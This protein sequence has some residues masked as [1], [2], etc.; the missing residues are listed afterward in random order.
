MSDDN[1]TA[2]Q[3]PAIDPVA[4][5]RRRMAAEDQ[6]G[7]GI[8]S[9]RRQVRGLWILSGI[10]LALVLVLAAF[11][12]LPRL[13]GVRMFGGQGNFRG[14]FTPGQGQQFQG[15]PGQGQGQPGQGQGQ[16]GQGL[17]Q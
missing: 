3:T 7:T 5:A 15:Q 16:P 14:N 6:G 10:T 1:V 9:L 8:E 2:G 12:F 4:E 17:G 13:F 11:T